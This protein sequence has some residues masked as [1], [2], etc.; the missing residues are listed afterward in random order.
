MLKKLVIQCD[1]EK[2]IK[3]RDEPEFIIFEV[4]EE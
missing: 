4:P 1:L 3:I 2:A